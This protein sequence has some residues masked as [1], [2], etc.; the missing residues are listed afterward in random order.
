MAD[1]DVTLGELRRDLRDTQQDHERR[2]AEYRQEN[3]RALAELQRSFDKLA[4]SIQSLPFVRQDVYEERQRG[5]GER[6]GKIE[7]TLSKI[8][9]TAWTGVVLPLTVMFVG[10]MLLAA[11]HL[12]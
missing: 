2:I 6:V 10:V 12:K 9:F 3:Q 7:A 8:N 4:D 11:V 5:T 1:N